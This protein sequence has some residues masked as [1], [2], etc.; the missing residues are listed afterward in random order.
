MKK[1][2]EKKPIK[3]N[4]TGVVKGSDAKKEFKE[5]IEKYR[6]QNPVKYEGV[7]GELAKKLAT[8]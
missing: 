2:K 5:F 1:K 4:D 6:L 8:L 3:V 7:K